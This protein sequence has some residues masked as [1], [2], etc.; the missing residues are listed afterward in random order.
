MTEDT[1]KREDRESRY[2]MTKLQVD[3][4]FAASVMI[5][6]LAILFGLWVVFI[7]STMM[8]VIIG[9]EIIVAVVGLIV[10][11]VRKEREFGQ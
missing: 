4:E 9:A 10:I 5:G 3:F 11:M 2:E 8:D 6:L 1:S 7:G